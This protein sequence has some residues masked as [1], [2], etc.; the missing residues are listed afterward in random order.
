MSHQYYLHSQ[1][2]R[3][4]IIHRQYHQRRMIFSIDRYVDDLIQNSDRD[5]TNFETIAVPMILSKITKKP[6]TSI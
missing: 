1:C 2:E 3:A 6:V 4:T 5:R